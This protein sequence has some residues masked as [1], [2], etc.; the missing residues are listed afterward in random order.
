MSQV[1]HRILSLSSVVSA[2]LGILLFLAVL[3]VMRLDAQDWTPVRIVG[4]PYVA[5]A[6]DARI[7]GVVRLRCALNSDGLV[8]KIEVIS[9]HKFFLRAVLE[10]ARQW[11]FAIGDQP[12]TSARNALLIYEFRLTDPVCESRY[13]E[14]FV[15]DQPD[16]ILVTSEFPCWRPDSEIEKRR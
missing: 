10:N 12:N 2:P 1:R 7:Q 14:Q 15:F 9:G 16:R 3:C 13:K 8:A 5:E 11:R 6:R 4:M